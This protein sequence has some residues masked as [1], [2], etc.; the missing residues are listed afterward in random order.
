[1]G[2]DADPPCGLCTMEFALVGNVSVTGA[3]VDGWGGGGGG[4]YMGAK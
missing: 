2:R 4:T 3:Y 1:M